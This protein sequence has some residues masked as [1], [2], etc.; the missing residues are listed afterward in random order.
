MKSREKWSDMKSTSEA[1]KLKDMKTRLHHSVHTYIQEHN[2]RVAEEIIINKKF[3]EY[4]TYVDRLVQRSFKYPT[5]SIIKCS[6][7]FNYYA[8]RDMMIDKYRTNKCL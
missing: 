4:T 7:G 1:V 2:A 6:Y 8:N 5:T 3:K